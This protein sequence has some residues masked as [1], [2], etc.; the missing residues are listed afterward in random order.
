M[1]VLWQRRRL[2][3]VLLGN[4]DGTFRGA[5]SYDMGGLGAGKVAIADINGDGP[6]DILVA[7]CAGM[8]CTNAVAILLGNGDGSFQAPLPFDSGGLGA[9]SVG[10]ADLNGDGLP[11]VLTT[12]CPT[13]PCVN[14]ALAVL[15]NATPP[16]DTT[17]PVVAVSVS[18]KELWPPNG[19]LV[20]VTLVRH[21][22]RFRFW[23]RPY[24]RDVRGQR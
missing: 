16:P 1:H 6:P 15:V 23:S 12:T 22:H 5:V 8:L 4:G 14:A 13:A 20:P 21:N 9:A 7:S 11:E 19:R 24:Q 2:V 10:A 18:P 17:P 3:G